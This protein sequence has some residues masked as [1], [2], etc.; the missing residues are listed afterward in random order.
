MLYETI[1]SQLKIGQTQSKQ[2]AKLQGPLYILRTFLMEI[3]I[4]VRNTLQEL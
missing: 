3:D 4:L 1:I 2:G